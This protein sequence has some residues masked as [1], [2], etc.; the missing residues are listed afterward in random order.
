MRKKHKSTNLLGIKH[1][2]EV[3]KLFDTK[4][5]M[6]RMEIQE[7]LGIS[8]PSAIALIRRLIENGDLA[9]I[10]RGKLSRY[11]LEAKQRS[12]S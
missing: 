5:S 7:A 1:R 9:K 11:R 12:K 8:Q 3:M 4:G 6:T 2:S 10:G